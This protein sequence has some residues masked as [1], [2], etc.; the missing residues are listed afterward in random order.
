MVGHFETDGSALRGYLAAAEGRQALAGTVEG[1]KLRFD[2]KVEKPLKI[3]LK[4]DITIDGNKLAGKC[5][6]GIFGSAK[7]S[8]QKI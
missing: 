2:L 6:M 3:T 7:L 1:N 8:G 4:Y 5:K